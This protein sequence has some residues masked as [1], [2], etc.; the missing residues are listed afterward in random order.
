MSLLDRVRNGAW[1]DEQEFPPLSWAVPGIVPEGFGLL[2]GPPKAG[3]SWAVLGIALA[4]AAGTPALGSVLLKAP[5]PV[6]MLA[7][8]DGDRRIKGRCRALLDDGERIP[9][10]FEYVTRATGSE[11]LDLVAEWLDV[12][13]EGNPL[14]ILDTLG[15]V[16][17]PALPGEGAYQRD[18][19]VGARLKALVDAH[20]GSTLLVVHHVRKASSDGADWMDSTSGTNGLNGSADFTV[21][22]ARQRNSV[23]GTLRVT[24]RDVPENEYAVTHKQGRWALVGGSL[25]EAVTAAREARMT[26]DLSDRSAE[27]FRAVA[28]AKTAVG[29]TE[30]GAQL[31]MPANACGVYL[32]RLADAGRI[33][34]KGR[35]KYVVETVEALKTD[36]PR[37]SIVTD[38]FN[39]TTVSTPPRGIFEGVE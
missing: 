11:V 14:V 5:K 9:E 19:R 13:G 17:P 30:V 38:T 33:T 21:N 3:K 28:G 10:R 8:E 34:R 24:G 4:V 2:T 31:G 7:L 18:Y 39:E 1:L 26:A 29:P 15:R 35:G 32:Q 12:N 6:L 25:N 22:L 16:M 37:L 20:P 23:E 36:H 27:V